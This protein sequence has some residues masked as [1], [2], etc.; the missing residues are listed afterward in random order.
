MG[1]GAT[2]SPVPPRLMKT[3]VAGRPLPQGVE[4]C[5]FNSTLPLSWPVRHEFWNCGHS[6]LTFALCLLTFFCGSAELSYPP[7]KEVRIVSPKQ[8][9][10]QHGGIS[11]V[12]ILRTRGILSLLRRAEMGTLA[13][14]GTPKSAKIPRD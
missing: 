7:P 9:T 11:T 1:S 2:P 8:C 4:G 5:K 10:P 6:L 3:P 14:P 12:Q 13:R